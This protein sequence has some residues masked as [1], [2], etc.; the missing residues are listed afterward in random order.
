MKKLAPFATI[1]TVAALGLSLTASDVH[2]GATAS[3]LHCE[4]VSGSVFWGTTGVASTHTATITCG[5]PVDH[6]LGTTV[7]FRTVMQDLSSGFV[8][9]NGYVHN[10]DGTQLAASGNMSTSSCTSN[11]LLAQEATVTVNPQSG[12]Y[13]YSVRCT[14]PANSMN[15]S[16]VESIR[17]Y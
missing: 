5:I 13:V 2:A 11:C 6:Q 7:R 4:P 8:N 16:S 12:S 15:Y 1:S 10:L 17:A 9:C 14:L 3:G